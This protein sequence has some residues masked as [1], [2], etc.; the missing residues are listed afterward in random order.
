MVVSDNTSFNPFSLA[1]KRVLI[2]G[3]SSGLGQAI[4]LSCAR[5]GAEL[6]ITGRN[7]DR[8]TK[9]F[10]ELQSISDL[11][12]RMVAADLVIAA[13]REG[14]IEALGSEIHGLVHSAGISRLCPTRM[15][16]EA[17]L[18]ELHATNVEAPI[19][20]SQGILKRNLLAADGSILF[21]ASIAAHIGVAGVGAYSG[22]KAALIA[23]SR[24]L[25]M[26]VVK[27]RIRVNCLSPS[28]VETPLF[29]EAAK[30]VCMKAQLES[31]PLGFGKP[32]DVANAAIF[33]LSGASRWITGTT[34]VMD[35]GLTIN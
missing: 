2:T 17:H 8:L 6:I 33:M 16:G 4:A 26:E 31:H 21:I 11:P 29:D 5:M 1:G 19:L 30:V 34:L 23:M 15:M 10:E 28:M 27:R 25:A 14:V 20:L 7:Q 9:T 18:R 22:T 3:A 32:E 12:H 24:C 13:E 35:G